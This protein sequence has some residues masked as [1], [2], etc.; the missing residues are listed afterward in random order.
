MG[1]KKMLRKLLLTTALLFAPSSL[2]FSPKAQKSIRAFTSQPLPVSIAA[3]SEQ[4]AAYLMQQARDC[5]FSDSWRSF[6][7]AQGYLNG[8]LEVRSGC[9]G[10]A[11]VGS[12]VCENVDEAAMIVARLREKI[13]NGQSVM[14]MTRVAPV[15]LSP[16]AL[17]VFVMYLSTIPWGLDATPFTLEE[18]TWAFKGGYAD[19]MFADFMRNGSLN[20]ATPFTLEE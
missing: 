8:V 4:D 7:E 18:W 17:M 15:V 1:K 2:G 5:A 3:N 9:A 20:D 14:M 11:L 6:E 12:E 10:G 16:V 13:A 19:T